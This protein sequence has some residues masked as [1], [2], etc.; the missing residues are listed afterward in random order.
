MSYEIRAHDPT[1]AVRR[2]HLWLFDRLI[3]TVN[4]LSALASGRQHSDRAD[5]RPAEDLHRRVGSRVWRG[6]GSRRGS[7]V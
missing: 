4:L 6:R 5:A 7:R 3:Q 2:R 1:V